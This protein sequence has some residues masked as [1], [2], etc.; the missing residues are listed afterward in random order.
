MNSGELR[1]AKF[2]I[3]E[4][5]V[6]SCYAFWRRIPSKCEFCGESIESTKKCPESLAD[7]KTEGELVKLD[8]LNFC[9]EDEDT[10][11]FKLTEFR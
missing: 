5:Y 6:T 2:S 10:P 8:A 11:Q 4:N 1:R 7:S 9:Q 3:L